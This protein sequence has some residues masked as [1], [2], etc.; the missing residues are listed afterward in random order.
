MKKYIL[1]ETFGKEKRWVN[2]RLIK[3]K[4]KITKIPFSVTGGKASSVDPE[5]WATYEE[6][7]EVSPQ[8]GIIFT[9]DQMLLG[10][11]IDHCLTGNKVTHEEREA[12][13]N[14]IIEADTY[15]EISPSKTGLH[16]FFKLTEPFA[17]ATNKHAPYELYTKGRYFTVTNNPYKEAKK[18]RT[19][20]PDEMILLLK[21]IGYPW[22]KAEE[23]TAPTLLNAPNSFS[24][25]DEDISR[26]MFAAKNGKDIQLLY[27]GDL[28]AYNGDASSADMALLSHLAFWTRKDAGQM[29]RIWMASPLGKRKKTQTRKDY[30]DRSVAAAIK[31][32]TTVYETQAQKMELANPD[33]DLLFTLNREKEKVFTQNTENMCR[34]LRKHAEFI[35]RFRYDVFKNVMEIR[36]KKTDM[37]RTLEDND[38]VNIQ[39]AISIL[40]P[41]FGKVGKDMIY[42]AIIK[43][44]KEHEIDSAADFIKGIVWDGEARLDS[45]LTKVYG[46]EDNKY[47]RAVGS[48]WLKGL[49]KRIIHPGCKFDYVLVLEGPQGTKKSTSLAIL[50][51]NW[52]VETTMSTDSKDFFMQFQGKAI[53]EFSE[54]ETL[55]RTEVKRM[56]AI[57]TMQTDKYRPPY[58]RTSQEFPRRCVFA[59]TT[60]QDEYL[61]DETGNRRWL[62]VAVV[63]DEA[64]VE[65]LEANR[66]Q[67]LAE[68]YKR[69]A[70]DKETIYEFPKEETIAEQD[71]RRIHYENEDMIIDWYYGKLTP[72]NREDGIT[73]QQVYRDVLYSSFASKPMDKYTEM[74]IGETL[75]SGLHLTRRQIMKDKVRL[76]RWFDDRGG[77]KPLPV[78]SEEDLEAEK[79]FGGL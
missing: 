8:V 71:K 13:A 55:S 30:R 16:L 44:S 53:I 9:P 32:C 49:V 25:N 39:T 74:K 11:D 38:A 69:V 48:N 57:I 3:A 60:N 73:V 45:W 72:F 43:V 15:T 66:N 6:A 59:M 18:V 46:V 35:G 52:H 2:Y 4:G 42:D 64:D 23:A 79:V 22:E 29:E 78:M 28:N 24:L 10:V 47:H 19:V 63:A 67:L 21:L 40:L 76:W 31:A 33:L 7:L 62:P 26:K 68:A 14:F 34:V 36:P 50:G 54:G 5:T 1:A 27:E 58:E 12:I 51:G 41:C 65:W 70:V 75:R 56:K 37:W 61:K 20:S 77:V 17:P